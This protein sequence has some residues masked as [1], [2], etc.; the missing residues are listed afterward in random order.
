MGPFLQFR[1]DHN[2]SLS[3]GRCRAAA[4]CRLCMWQHSR[5]FQ[6]TKSPVAVEQHR[7]SHSCNAIPIALHQIHSNAR[8]CI[9]WMWMML[10]PDLQELCDK[11]HVFSHVGYVCISVCALCVQFMCICIYIYRRT[12]YK[13]LNFTKKSFFF[14]FLIQKNRFQ[15]F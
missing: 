15:S 3:V 4:V 10:C 8:A 14:F 2:N 13:Q 5:A 6:H 12:N 9:L 11:M 1:Q 7:M